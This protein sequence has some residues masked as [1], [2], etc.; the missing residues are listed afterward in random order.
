MPFNQ[1]HEIQTE[2]SKYPVLIWA[3]GFDQSHD[4]FNQAWLDFTG[5]DVQQNINTGWFQ[6]IHPDD[7]PLFQLTYERAQTA[8]QSF[9]IE[10]R[11]K[12]HDGTYRWMQCSAVPRPDLSGEFSGHIATNTDIHDQLVEKTEQ[13][14]YEENYELFLNC[15]TEGIWDWIDVN[16][17]E[18]WWSPHFYELLG[19]CDQEIEA[20]F[21]TF[22][23][24]L[25]SDDLEGTLHSLNQALENEIP[26]DI[27]FRFRVKGGEYHWFRSTAKII[28]D[29]SG[30]AVRMTG[31]ISDIHR[32]VLAEEELKETRRLA[33]QAQLEKDTFLALMSQEV[34][35]PLSAILGFSEILCESSDDPDTQTA[36]ETIHTNGQSL[37]D[38]IN[39]F[40]A[41]S[42]IEEGLLDI[43]LLDCCPVTVIENVQVQMAKKA[44]MKD[45]KF[46][47]QYETEIPETIKSDPIRLKQILT[48]VI[49]TAIKLTQRGSV[50][51]GVQTTSLEN[52]THQL[53]FSVR[54]TGTELSIEQFSDLFTPYRLTDKLMTHPVSGLGLGLAVS[55][56]LTEMLGGQIQVK[57]QDAFNTT[58]EFTIAAGDISE[59]KME[60][61]S[62]SK[63]LEEIKTYKASHDFL[64]QD[65]HILLVED[66][67]YN[68]RLINFLL[69]K[70][71]A[72]I[73]IVENGQQAI[74]ELQKSQEI[75]DPIGEPYDLILMDI[76][77]PVLDGYSTTRKIRALGYTKP[78]IALTI[79][80]MDSDRQKC[81][82]AGCDEYMSKPLERKKLISIINSFL[83]KPRNQNLVAK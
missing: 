60:K 71:G 5:S 35:T 24:L 78:I 34:R 11:L 72:E 82:D 50:K 56:H 51:L 77:M 23:R 33:E 81:F 54:N 14:T 16:S 21:S 20:S 26:F 40:L 47:V 38:T 62:A 75:G 12:K 68:Q 18:Q 13:I 53:T 44:E 17:D 65:C 58:V 46:E 80:A 29:P 3:S 63:R 9:Q 43:Q 69:T 32:Q 83:K 67:I 39:D 1:S 57:G 76:Q 70:A 37:L 15:I 22:K 74:D 28:R 7:L 19:Y 31:S 25:H 10:F 61:V 64:K 41:L 48:T 59:V 49:G 6:F 52:G 42:Q 30:N 2:N 8:Q 55:K 66:G 27:K 45:L 36:A 4:F 73:T 79:H